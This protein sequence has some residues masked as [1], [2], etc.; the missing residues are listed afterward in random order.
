MGIATQLL[1]AVAL[2]LDY[3]VAWF[4]ALTW[5]FVG[6]IIY[7]FYGGKKTIETIEPEEERKGL[8]ESLRERKDEKAYKILVPVVREDQKPLVEFAALVARVEDADLQ[9]V[10]VRETP[11]AVPPSS[12]KYKDM[13]PHIKLVDKLKKA[14]D[15]EL[16][17][18]RGSILIS[19][20]AS[21]A[22]LDTVKDENVNLLILGWEGRTSDGRIFGTTIDKLVQAAH[23]DAVVFK[24]AGLKKEIKKILMVSTPDWH[25]TFATSYAIL[26][27]KR[28]EA[29]ITIFSASSSKEAMAKEEKDMERL[30]EMCAS[31]NVPHS[32][33]IIRADSIEKAIIEESQ[34]YDLVVMGASHE[35]KLK[36]FAF[37]PLQD[38]VARTVDKPIL[39]VRKV[40][41]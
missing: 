3:I 34:N 16:I 15:R 5:I 22:I 23:C 32:K 12:L 31:H 13:A 40:K 30:C 39:M 35:W 29:E 21:S 41:K 10:S 27:A 4:I 18:S 8:F 14:S 7:Y 26:F 11:M 33:K 9:I 25:V 24:T 38:K 17:K 19:H 28:D 20:E 36:K 6:L 2:L 37:G 1:L